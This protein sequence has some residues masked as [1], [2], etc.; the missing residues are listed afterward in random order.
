MKATNWELH[1]YHGGKIPVVKDGKHDL[2]GYKPII[3]SFIGRGHKLVTDEIRKEGK[4]VKAFTFMPEDL[5]EETGGY[6]RNEAN[7]VKLVKVTQSKYPTLEKVVVYGIY[8][9]FIGHPGSCVLWRWEYDL[10]TDKVQTDQ[11]P[12]TIVQSFLRFLPED[13]GI[14]SRT[15]L[16][17][18][19]RNHGKPIGC[20]E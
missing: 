16:D 17:F 9:G 5:E 11:L 13:A 14:A 12:S 1:F 6:N 3:N 7:L 15:L 18:S 4:E 19:A 20:I 10:K 2:E 8:M